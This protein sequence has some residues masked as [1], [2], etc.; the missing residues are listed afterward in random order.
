[1]RRDP[2]FVWFDAAMADEDHGGV[3]HRNSHGN[4]T[5]VKFD[6]SGNGSVFASSQTLFPLGPIHAVGLAFDSSGNLYAGDDSHERILKFDPQGKASVFVTN[7]SLLFGAQGMAIDSSGNLYVA[8][9]YN[10]AVAKFDTNGVGS[11]FVSPVFIDT[12]SPP[13]RNSPTGLAFDSSGN[14]CVGND[15]TGLIMKFDANGKGSMFNSIPTLGDIN[16]LAIDSSGNLYTT[17]YS[18]NRVVKRDPSGHGT[19]IADASDGLSGPRFIAVQI[20]E[21]AT[22]L[23]AT[24]SA[25]LLWL[26][27]RRKQA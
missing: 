13:I 24:A 27:L 7:S 15:G 21:P 6:P 4:G 14:L 23:L 9:N 3:P 20:P 1:M 26:L 8:R 16:G 12:N 5:I 17:T 22:W 18:D 10:N 2:S 25:V 19:I 11:V